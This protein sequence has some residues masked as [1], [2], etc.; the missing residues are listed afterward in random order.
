VVRELAIRIMPGRQRIA[1]FLTR[2][3]RHFAHAPFAP[4]EEKVRRLRAGGMSKAEAD[5]GIGTLDSEATTLFHGTINRRE[6]EFRSL[7]LGHAI[8]ICALQEEPK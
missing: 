8:R 7:G 1:A 3:A 6:I 5:M 2:S 4:E